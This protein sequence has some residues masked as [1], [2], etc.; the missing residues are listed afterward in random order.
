MVDMWSSRVVGAAGDDVVDGSSVTKFVVAEGT[1]CEV[2]GSWQRVHETVDD[3]GVEWTLVL[4]ADEGD[5][6]GE[7]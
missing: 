5:D 2:I 3:A 6:I 1:T 4:V 7:N